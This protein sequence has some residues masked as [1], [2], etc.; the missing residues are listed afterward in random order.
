MTSSN[1]RRPDQP[2]CNGARDTAPNAEGIGSVCAHYNLCYFGPGLISLEHVQAEFRRIST[3]QF[4]AF[5]GSQPESN[6]LIAPFVAHKPAHGRPG[7][8]QHLQRGTR[9]QDRMQTAFAG[10]LVSDSLQQLVPRVSDVTACR[11]AW[12]IRTMMIRAVKPDRISPR[13]LPAPALGNLPHQVPRVHGYETPCDMAQP[14][15]LWA[16]QQ[17]RKSVMSEALLAGCQ[18]DSRGSRNA[19]FEWSD[20]LSCERMSTKGRSSTRCGR[21]R[22][23]RR[24]AERQRL[25]DEIDLA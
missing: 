11:Q 8:I 24:A 21:R 20:T 25:S 15:K 16:I 2:D 3:A 13:R 22:R 23:R 9:I 19:A 14:I 17:C 18:N 5:A 4:G 7:S 10:L 1:L 6:L 12:Q